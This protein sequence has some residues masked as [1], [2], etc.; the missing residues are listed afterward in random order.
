MLD[1]ILSGRERI[2]TRG[3]KRGTKWIRLFQ[4]DMDSHAS[5]YVGILLEDSPKALPDITPQPT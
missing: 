5:Q 3:G 4:D 1:V 2:T